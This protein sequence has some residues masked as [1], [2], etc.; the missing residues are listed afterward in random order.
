MWVLPS[1]GLQVDSLDGTP[2]SIVCDD[3]TMLK[4]LR[5]VPFFFRK[6]LRINL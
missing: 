1:P 5:T 4:P 6:T 2:E 3:G